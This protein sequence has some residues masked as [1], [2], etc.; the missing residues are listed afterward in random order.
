MRIRF[1]R[2]GL[3][4]GLLGLLVGGIMTLLVGSSAA[5]DPA[6][7]CTPVSPTPGQ[8]V[9]CVFVYTG[10]AQSWSVPAGVTDATVDV[11]GAAGGDAAGGTEAGGL[12]G[13]ASAD[14]PLTPAQT[15]TVDVGGHGGGTDDLC[16]GGVGA[17]GGFNGGE[18]GGGASGGSIANCPGAGGGGASD[19]RIGGTSLSDRA[20]V[21]GGGG[22][23][24]NAGGFDPNDT[25]IF[26]TADGG[27]GGGLTGA[28]GNAA[29]ARGGGG[30]G[31]DQSG[32]SGSGDLGTGSAGGD[33][34]DPFVPTGG[35]GGGGGYYGGAGGGGTP[36]VGG[37][38]GG[39]GFIP[40]GG[41]F[42]TGVRSADGLVTI[43]YTEP[44]P[45][46]DLTITKTHTGDFTQ[47]QTGD[48]T[49]TVTNSGSAPTSGTVT[50]TDT[51]PSGLAA[52]VIISSNAWACS[53]STST[54]MTCT[55]SSALAAGASSTIT[56]T[57]NVA[58][59]AQS[60]TNTASVS[61]G[62]ETNTANDTASDPT[63]VI[64][65]PKVTNATS[66][67]ANGAYRVGATVPV[68]VE[69]SEA[70]VVTGTPQL[71][72]NSG[73]GVRANYSS[74][75]GSSTL[76]FSYTVAAGQ[77]SADLD[78][79]S[80]SSLTLNG[81][82]IKDAANVAANLT[83]PTP[84][85]THSLG[86][87]KDIVIDTIPPVVTCGAT[88]TFL[89]GSTGN[90]VSATVT[91]PGGS[92]PLSSPVTAAAPATT[93]GPQSAS[94]TGADNAGNTTVASCPYVVGYK[95]GGF[96]S[97]LPKSTVN[98]GS[99]LPIKFQLQDAA[100]HPISDT[101]AQSLLAPTCKITIILVKPAGPVSGCP[102]YSTTSKQFQFNLRTTNAM[103]GANGVSITVTIGGTIVTASTPPDPFTVK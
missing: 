74:G 10:G 50:V 48:Y 32:A 12:G 27:G 85:T 82:T 67:T 94:V 62:G 78:Y 76:T 45:T 5:A 8:T 40:T 51:L 84:G 9:T 65:T 53:G 35:G 29:G 46:P 92:G 42:E 26:I 95:F 101:E 16:L 90:Q 61:G 66:T 64:A 71:A 69:F 36:N 89:L 47:G 6:A 43:S 49:I 3:R 81:G 54:V 55:R 57:V 103:K 73:L 97:P 79:T 100:G 75:S 88:P 2:G 102:T 60:V 1:R 70:V 39:S 23:A 38:G 58:S 83:L 63:T 96:T 28:N 41:S 93:A 19:V 98:S 15:V 91:D 99:T 80:P 4:L 72:L 22:G 7:G 14:L 52:T 59:D 11:Y 37:G 18:P 44:T 21:A 87:N 17:T 24:A 13:H 30:S 56:L 34:N 33:G 20:L 25:S 31:G 77:N 86:F 68:T